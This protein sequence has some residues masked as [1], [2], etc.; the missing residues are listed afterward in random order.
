MNRSIFRLIRRVNYKTVFLSVILGF[1]IINTDN[2]KAA[3]AS[4]HIIQ[5]M[6]CEQED[7]TWFIDNIDNVYRIDCI[8]VAGFKPVSHIAE[9]KIMEVYFEGEQ[10]YIQLVTVANEQNERQRLNILLSDDF[11]DDAQL[12]ATGA[13]GYY[14]EGDKLYAYVYWAGGCKFDQPFEVEKITYQWNLE[15][16]QYQREEYIFYRDPDTLGRGWICC[17]HNLLDATEELTEEQQLLL[18]GVRN[19]SKL[20]VNDFGWRTFIWGQQARDL[21]AEAQERIASQINYTSLWRQHSCCRY[22]Y[23]EDACIQ[24]LEPIP[25]PLAVPFNH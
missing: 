21:F 3:Q 12:Q 8:N 22:E 4:K 14:I 10:T 18:Q 24:Q 25:K 16:Q 1:F 15:S 13:G 23:D 2:V 11:S 19:S 9:A 20:W 6:N 7:V 17:N 5:I